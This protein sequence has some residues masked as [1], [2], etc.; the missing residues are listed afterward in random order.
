MPWRLY[1]DFSD[2]IF[3]WLIGYS[4]LLGPIAGI[5]LCDYFLIRRTKLI[6]DDLYSSTGQYAGF[7]WTT[8]LIL[9][10]AVAPN[11]PGFIN[12]A[13]DTDYFPEFF[14]QLYSYAWFVGITIAF[15]L[16][17]VLNIGERNRV[18]TS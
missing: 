4:A 11:L 1:I 15:V 9:L 13:F 3:T 5:M 8:V 14:N 17:G 12:E 10:I 16:Y 6:A 2:Y 18:Q 7:R